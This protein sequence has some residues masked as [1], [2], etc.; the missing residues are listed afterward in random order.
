MTNPEIARHFREL[1]KLMEL[2]GDNPFKIRS[3]TNAYNKLRKDERDLAGMS[4]TE[5]QKLEG[6][7][8]AIAGKIHELA[9]TGQDGDPRKVA[10]PDPGGHPRDA[11]H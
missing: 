11:P 5:L 3:Y 1:A 4:E 8:K 9:T 7:G 2:H 10:R 6:V